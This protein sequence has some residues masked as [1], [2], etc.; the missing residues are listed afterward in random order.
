MK[1][2]RSSRVQ[3]GNDKATAH[4][5]EREKL[6]KCQFVRSHDLLYMAFDTNSDDVLFLS[7]KT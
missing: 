3:G 2:I 1:G 7:H 5:L 6:L 4:S